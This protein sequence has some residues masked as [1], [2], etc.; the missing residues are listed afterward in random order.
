MESS[1]TISIGRDHCKKRNYC[2]YIIYEKKDDTSN[3]VKTF[4]R[5][6]NDW[7]E[8]VDDTMLH[9]N[10]III[11]CNGANLTVIPEEIRNFRRLKEFNCSNNNLVL[12]PETL[13][14]LE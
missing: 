1:S 11:E 10:A 13:S 4:L 5:Y 7:A 9:E 6:F 14:E 2:P 12:L 8:I 3:Q